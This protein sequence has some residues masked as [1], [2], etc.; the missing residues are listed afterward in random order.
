MKKTKYRLIVATTCVLLLMTPIFLLVCGFVLPP[1]YDDTFL[2]ELKY[3]CEAL[4]QT[5]GKRIIFVG[6]SSVAF[7]VDSAL[8]AEKLPEYSVVNFGMYA[9]LGTK[10]MLDLSMD[11]VRAGDI[12]IISPEQ[13]KQTLSNY[14]NG[15]AMWQALDGAFPLLKRIDSGDI[16]NLVGQF[17]YFASEKLGYVMEK[18]KPN[19]EGVY[20]R[21]AFNEYG[22]VVAR[23][24]A[25]NTMV[26]E[27]DRNTLISFDEKVLD[28]DFIDYLNAYAE[29]LTRRGATVWYRFC[30]MNALA[31]EEGSDIDKYYEF[32]QSKLSFYVIGDPND[33]VMEKEWFYDTNFH[34]NASGKVINTNQIIR[35]IKAMLGDNT[36]TN[37]TLPLKPEIPGTSLILG[38]NSDEDC[39][40][41]ENNNGELT[42]VGVTQEGALREVLTIPTTYSGLPI[43]KVA[44][45][46]FAGNT[47]IHTIIIQ[48]NIASISDYAFDGCSS[49]K[50]VRLESLD[51]N[52]CKIG[53]YLLEGTGAVITVN[54]DV[55]S[56]YKLNYFWSVY[57]DRIVS[58]LYPL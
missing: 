12:V 34:L 45:S 58:Y 46:V 30:P 23:E 8:V 31:I 48:E 24:C 3:K 35:D 15:E 10:V 57:T 21:S 14:F 19:P 9:G 1:Q 53:Q 5:K 20:N 11:S 29:E 33:C 22:D 18:S 17:P 38:D 55:L 41:Y 42:L 28:A 16:G 51:P 54:K 32:L 56:D 52:R 47:K 36:A 49:L 26:E 13:E 7:G 6:G 39:F 44:A 37:I 25:Y 4:D 27:Y 50:I 43:T 40:T 2:G